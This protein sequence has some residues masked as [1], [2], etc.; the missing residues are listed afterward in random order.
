MA[1]LIPAGDH[2]H[3]SLSHRQVVERF[4]AKTPFKTINNLELTWNVGW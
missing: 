3:L 4:E 1:V 2:S